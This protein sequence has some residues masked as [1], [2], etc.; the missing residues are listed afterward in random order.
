[1]WIGWFYFIK[2]YFYIYRPAGLFASGGYTCGGLLLNRIACIMG[3]T[4][5]VNIILLYVIAWVSVLR[6]H[7]CWWSFIYIFGKHYFDRR[8]LRNLLPLRGA[9]YLSSCSSFTFAPEGAHAICLHHVVTPGAASW[10]GPPAVTACG[11]YWCRP[12]GL[13]LDPRLR[14]AR[15]NW[16]HLTC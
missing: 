8:L 9:S 12:T 14:A 1:M 11:Y 4:H 16:L 6:Y 7:G 13:V 5:L 10:W 3:L 2:G 15:G